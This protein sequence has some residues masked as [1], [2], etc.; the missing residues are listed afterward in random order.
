M[1]WWKFFRRRWW[2]DERSREIASYIEIETA[3]NI[4]RGMS[5]PEAASA[6]RRRL[7]SPLLVREE[8]YRMNSIAWLENTWE[9]LRHGARLMRLSPGF[10]LVALAS[11]ALGIGANTAIF[12]LIDAVRLRSLP[13]SNPSELAEVRIDGGNHGLGVNDGAYAQLTRPVWREIRDQQQAFS[14]VFAWRT[15]SE[16]VG[17]GSDQTSVSSILVTGDFFQV[18]G[19]HPWRGRLLQPDDERGCPWQVAVLSYGYWQRQMGGRDL[20]PDS[21]MLIDGNITQIVGVTPP[22]FLGLAVGESFDIALPF[23]EPSTELRRDVF[24]ISVMGRLRPGWTLDRASAQLAAISPAIFDATAITGYR[25]ESIDL[26]KS[27]RLAAYPAASGVSQL[28]NDY[29]AS[30]LILLGITALVLLIAC[31]NLANLML[32]RASARE[33]ETAVRL[34]LGASRGRLLRQFLTESALLA[35]LGAVAG[36][37]LAQVLSRVLVAAFS[38]A[39]EPLKLTITPDWRVMSFVA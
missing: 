13:V 23:C 9:D 17:E 18:L 32:A 5:P 21:K 28:R 8:I 39:N 35:F 37:A 38:P 10:A 12:Q 27:F 20:G 31:A 33:R 30:L 16:D 36:V 6:A 22:G 3:D 15:S 11:L 2:D 29:D 25:A 14:G 4:A 7:G 24:D 26:Y 1:S 34:A 19:L